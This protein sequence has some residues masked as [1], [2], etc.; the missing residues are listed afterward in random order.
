MILVSQFL[1]GTSPLKLG[2][3]QNISRTGF[4]ELSKLQYKP[5]VKQKIS[6]VNYCV[7]YIFTLLHS[8]YR[9]L[10]H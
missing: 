5:L 8:L 2:K 3:K 6:D 9:L 1:F 7:N 4:C 10:L